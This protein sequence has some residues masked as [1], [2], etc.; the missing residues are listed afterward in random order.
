MQISAPPEPRALKEQTR[1]L[2]AE[3]PAAGHALLARG[4]W[5]AEPLWQLWG[6]QLID[7]GMSCEQLRR[8]AAGYENEMRLWLV[9]ERTWEHAIDGFIGRVNRRV[10][11]R[12]VTESEA[13]AMQHV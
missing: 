7:A 4:E 1:A 10:R 9:G 2:L 8:V 5:I 3:Q 12:T 13:S 11:T 6:R